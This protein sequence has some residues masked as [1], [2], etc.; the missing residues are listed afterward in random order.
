M[1]EASA[2]LGH[3]NPPPMDFTEVLREDL[4][5]QQ[6]V[7]QNGA[8]VERKNALLNAAARFEAKY[9]EKGIEDE[10]T[11]KSA[12]DF[13]KQLTAFAKQAE[14]KREDF[15]KPFNDANKVI[16]AFYKVSLTDPILAA[17]SKVNAKRTVYMQGV[18]K[19][20]REVREAEARR[21]KEIADAAAA[22][23]EKVRTAEAIDK[24]IEAE[25]VAEDAKAAVAAK[26]AEVTRIT[27]DLG[28]T[29]SLRR[30]LAFDV[31]DKA[32]VPLHLLQIVDGA[33]LAQGRIA[34][35]PVAEQPIPGI[36][37]RWVT[38]AG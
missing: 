37:F 12:Q 24:A 27:S 28:V 3:N 35:D 25:Q 11:A 33:V 30:T 6:I 32:K 5:R 22:E 36:S 26:P 10:E 21:Q 38:K 34:K 17:A 15:K 13:E 29:S 2:G 16:Q 18:E 20:A 19:R 31:T 14:G 1:S 9:G 23:A 8:L 7:M 4:L